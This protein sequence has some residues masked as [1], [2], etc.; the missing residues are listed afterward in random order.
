MAYPLSERDPK[1]QEEDARSFNNALKIGA[2]LAPD[3]TNP[4]EM[5]ELFMDLKSGMNAAKMAP[6]GPMIKG[7]AG[8]A[9]FGASRLAR[10]AVGSAV[11]EVLGTARKWIDGKGW[12]AQTAEG[13]N[14]PWNDRWWIPSEDQIVKTHM[15]AKAI[16]NPD[17]LELFPDPLQKIVPQKSPRFPFGE[18]IAQ[19]IEKGGLTEGTIQS[20]RDAGVSENLI[21]T[22]KN[23]ELTGKH[24]PSG[25][26]RAAAAA[27]QRPQF[28]EAFFELNR[29][30]LLPIFEKGFINAGT[31]LKPRLHHVAGLKGS[32]PLYNNIKVGGPA[33]NSVNKVLQESNVFPGHHFNNFKML[34]DESHQA[35]HRFMDDVIGPSGEV[36]FNAERKKLLNKSTAGRLKVAKEYGELVNR[37]RQLA[38]DI[39]EQYVKMYGKRPE[40]AE[41]LIHIMQEAEALYK[42]I[43]P[44]YSN[45]SLRK[46]IEDVEGLSQKQLVDEGFKI[47]QN[48][49]NLEE[50]VETGKQLPGTVTPEVKEIFKKP[51]NPKKRL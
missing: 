50:V 16:N 41:T 10:T 17:Q 29:L 1:R 24:L 12:V 37:S 22:M 48:L 19:I 11:D 2:S 18:S 23:W 38:V 40:D 36:F 32:L 33:Y 3:P 20:L 30:Q 25:Q 14:M 7:V 13:V 9:G 26:S 44:K 27:V 39:H 4:A 31:T 8:V 5:S 47:Q 35:I 21:F 15:M 49:S 45:K 42:K 34:S 51:K 46:I 6:G 43:G 28:S